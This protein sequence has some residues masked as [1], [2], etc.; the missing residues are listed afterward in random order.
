MFSNFKLLR[1]L[2]LL[3]LIKLSRL[4]VLITRIEDHMS[5]EKLISLVLI[6]KLLFYLLLIAHLFACI[7]F[8]ISVGN[9]SPNTMIYQMPTK[10]DEVLDSNIEFYISSLYWPLRHGINRLRAVPS[11]ISQLRLSIFQEKYNFLQL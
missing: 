11:N 7:M 2:K 5:N 10:S 4:K 1:V 9:L 6:I 8:S 3:K